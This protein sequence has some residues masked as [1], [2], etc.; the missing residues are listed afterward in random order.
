MTFAERKAA[1]VARG[2]VQPVILVVCESYWLPS[3][4]DDVAG[5]FKTW[6]EAVD[7]AENGGA[8]RVMWA[9]FRG[10]NDIG[11]ASPVFRVHRVFPQPASD[12]RGSQA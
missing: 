6:R 8:N 11:P 7:F 2:S 9:R 12:N 3:D 4:I 10:R 5:Q 1:R